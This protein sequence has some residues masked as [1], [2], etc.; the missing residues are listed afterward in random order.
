MPN[1]GASAD[2][3]SD[4]KPFNYTTITCY[5]CGLQIYPINSYMTLEELND[6]RE[7]NDLEP[8]SEL[9]AQSNNLW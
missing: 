6:L 4:W 7:E 1:C 9:P 8:L 5:N 3:Y 2:E